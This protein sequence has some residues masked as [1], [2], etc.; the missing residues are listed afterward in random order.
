M[1]SIPI[2]EKWYRHKCALT[3]LLY[4]HCASDS[5]LTVYRL[6][7]QCRPILGISGG[8]TK[9]IQHL[10]CEL[11]YLEAQGLIVQNIGLNKKQTQLLKQTGRNTVRIHPDT[12]WLLFFESILHDKQGLIACAYFF[13]S[14]LRMGAVDEATLYRAQK[15]LDMGYWRLRRAVDELVRLDIFRRTAIYNTKG[16]VQKYL[17][18]EVKRRG[19]Y[20]IPPAPG[21]IEMPG[22]GCTAQQWIDLY[23][24]VSNNYWE[25]KEKEFG[26]E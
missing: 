12:L 9:A 26:N 10:R 7:E 14:K 1:V 11:D 19:K 13:I 8:N 21:I 23:N 22:Q 16:K 5:T 6:E 3:A 24:E 25:E 20:N 15:Q 2:D 17:L 4:A 18:F